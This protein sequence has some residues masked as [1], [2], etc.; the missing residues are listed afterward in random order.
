MSR[1]CGMALLEL[2]VVLAISATLC[3]VTVPGVAATRGAFRA[4]GAAQRLSLV[5]RDAQA[6]AEAQSAPVRVCVS[7]DGSYTVAQTAGGGVIA[8]GEI[9][10]AVVG[11]YPDGTVE[12]G[13]SGLPTL[14]G[15]GSPR[16][17]HFTVADGAPGQTVVVQLGGCVRCT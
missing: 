2:V 6:Y 14:S 11:T 4:A 12:F 1:T 10:A 5:L 17:G 7:A 16:A 15:G 3:A 13:A 9:G 8:R